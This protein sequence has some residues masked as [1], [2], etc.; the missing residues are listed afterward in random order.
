MHKL[1][2]YDGK[3]YGEESSVSS[4]WTDG[5][6]PLY[7]TKTT[8]IS[9]I[10]KPYGFHSSYSS[11]EIESTSGSHVGFKTEVTFVPRHR[12]YYGR[13]VMDSDYIDVNGYCGELEKSANSYSQWT[14]VYPSA[15]HK[16]KSLNF[17]CIWLDTF[18]SSH[19]S[20]IAVRTRSA[21]DSDVFYTVIDGRTSEDSIAGEW[22][23]EE[24]TNIDGGGVERVK[25]YKIQNHAF[26][27][28][29]NSV[30]TG[31]DAFMFYIHTSV[32][33]AMQRVKSMMDPGT[34]S[35]ICPQKKCS[36]MKCV[37][38]WEACSS[39]IDGNL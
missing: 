8:H 25:V 38:Y 27:I 5:H 21:R 26:Y 34:T 23:Q 12:D 1:Q 15:H 24:A 7:Y 32:A 35:N 6:P 29:L 16:Y 37:F 20:Y 28:N 18:A 2:I 14:P 19:D 30:L 31:D 36:D 9:L 4:F 13:D 11:S 10:W 17:S 39:W 33:E 3:A 22:H